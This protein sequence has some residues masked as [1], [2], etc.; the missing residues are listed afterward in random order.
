MSAAVTRAIPETRSR[1]GLAPGFTVSEIVSPGCAW[2]V[3]ASCWSSAIS[4]DRSDPR[5]NRSVW[6]AAGYDRGTASIAPAPE[7][8]VP[9]PG[10]VCSS[11]A[12]GAV[13]AGAAWRTP[14]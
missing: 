10:A 13:A 9:T 12:N 4:P 8:I 3:A 1:T 7:R 5:R 2:S 14:A 6:K 11:P